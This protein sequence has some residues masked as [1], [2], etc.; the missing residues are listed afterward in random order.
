[1]KKKILIFMAGLLL[2]GANLFAAGDLQVNGSLGVGTVPISTK[3][4]I[5][6]TD[7]TGIYDL[8]TAS[9]SDALNAANLTMLIDGTVTGG[10]YSGFANRALHVGENASLGRMVGG[11]N[12]LQLDSTHS[13]ATA[14]ID[15][16]ALRA[17]ISNANNFARSYSFPLGFSVIQV[18][19]AF[20]DTTGGGLVTAPNLNG[21]SISAP[22]GNSLSV[23][24]VAGL[25]VSPQTSGSANNYGIVLEGD[26][27]GS[28][29]V[30]GPNQESRIYSQ[31]VGGVNRLYAQDGSGNQTVISPHDPVTGEWVFYS[32][33]VKTGRVVEVNME[34]LVKAVEKLTG[35]TFMVETLIQE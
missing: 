27:A 6:S 19:Y 17:R 1:M 23:S 15:G 2:T 24:N 21:I 7:E 10:N 33:N 28:D 32:K 14:I 34:K 3:L 30:F 35:E 8:T 13:G 26:G 4:T 20:N 22:S 9:T 5:N 31:D 16:A 29:L 18:S 11:D 12:L 25:W